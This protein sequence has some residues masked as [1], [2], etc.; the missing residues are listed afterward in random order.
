MKNKNWLK[1][2][3]VP[4]LAMSIIGFSFFVFATLLLREVKST[5][6]VTISILETVKM[7]LTLLIGYYF[8]SSKGSKDKDKIDPA[9]PPTS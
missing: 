8:G 4:L 7:I 3:I 2:N 1:D 5:D 9:T 6:T